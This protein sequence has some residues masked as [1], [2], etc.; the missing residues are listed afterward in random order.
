MGVVLVV[1][2]V[3]AIAVSGLA[4]HL[5]RSLGGGRQSRVRSV[6]ATVGRING[7]VS[8]WGLS[9][10]DLRLSLSSRDTESSTSPGTGIL[11]LTIVAIVVIVG[12]PL[13][14][15]IE[16][17]VIGASGGSGLSGS[18]VS[19]RLLDLLLGLAEGIREA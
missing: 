9:S 12:E 15:G 14:R 4:W 13:V 3:V 2:V 17:G 19:E 5:L 16:G 7:A 18:L 6:V 1:G 10:R 11:G 8:A